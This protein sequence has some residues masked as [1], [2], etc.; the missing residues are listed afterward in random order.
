[1]RA[2]NP[3]LDDVGAYL[4]HRL[5]L[6]RRQ[7]T[8]ALEQARQEAAHAAESALLERVKTK[9]LAAT[10]GAAP[11]EPNRG[12]GIGPELTEPERFGGLT[13]VLAARLEARRKTAGR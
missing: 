6:E 9:R 7:A 1:L 3:L 2:Q 10:L 4:A 8:A 12:R 13:T 5:E 11:A